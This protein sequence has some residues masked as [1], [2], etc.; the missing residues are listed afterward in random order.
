LGAVLLSG[1][2]PQLATADDEQKA[3]PKGAGQDQSQALA[4]YNRL[5]AKSPRSASEQWKL[6]LWC[7]KHGLAAEAV[8]HLGSVVRLEPSNAAAWKKL[9]FKKVDGRWMNEEQVAADSAQKQGEKLWAPRLKK[10]HKDIHGGKKQTEAQ[11]GIAT[12]EDP[13]AVSSVYR[14]FAGGGPVDQTIAIQVLGQIKSPIASKVLAFLSVYGK[15]PDVRRLAAETLRS[16]EPEE[17]L[18]VLVGLLTDLIKYHVQPV[19]GPGSPGILLVEGDQFNLKR[20]YAPSAPSV[21]PRP[22]DIISYDQNGMPVLT[23]PLDIVSNLARAPSSRAL[24]NRRAALSISLEQSLIETQKSAAVAQLQLDGDIA[25]IEAQN[26]ARKSFNELVLMVVRDATGKDIGTKREEWE[27]ALASPQAY[28]KKASRNPKPTLAEFVP[29]AYT[30]RISP[31][32]TFV[33]QLVGSS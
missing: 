1:C 13:N 10:W 31:E 11:A 3:T 5:R 32:L 24:F 17:Y 25:A 16:R 4:E 19:G 27:A 22:G 6:A 18:D 15:K 29:I 7:E 30:P 21:T 9:G 33:T 28:V 8:A 2:W 14:E 26:T 23:R 20:L 12:I